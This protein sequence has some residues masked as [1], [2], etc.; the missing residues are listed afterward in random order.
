MADEIFDDSGLSG[1]L[2]DSVGSRQASEWETDL[3]GSLTESELEDLASEPKPDAV[4]M[5]SLQDEPESDELEREIM[6]DV[7]R[8]GLDGHDISDSLL[9]RGDCD[10]WGEKDAEIRKFVTAKLYEGQSPKQIVGLL[11]LMYHP[12][13]AEAFWKARGDEALSKYGRLG[14]LYVDATDFRNDGEMDKA[15]GGQRKMGQMALEAIKPA[16]RCGD[17]T[18]NKGGFC[19]RYNLVLDDSPSVKNARQAR[20]ILNKFARRSEATDLQVAATMDKIDAIEADPKSDS[21]EYDTAVSEFLTVA[22]R[23]SRA[24]KGETARARMTGATSDASRPNPVHDVEIEAF[25]LEKLARKAQ[26]GFPELRGATM[27]AFGERRAKAWFRSNRGSVSLMMEEAAQ[28]KASA[29]EAATQDRTMDA[30]QEALLGRYGER[31]TA[32]FLA[33]RGSDPAT[34]ADL[35][36][37]PDTETRRIA[38]GRQMPRAMPDRSRPRAIGHLDDEL[39]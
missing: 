22:G 13:R 29:S 34:Y 17:C 23:P 3:L 9:V 5:A 28:S 33:T 1:I 35:L 30:V 37:K 4:R 26:A 38:T 25:V 10:G 6:R 8:S 36:A 2:G 39:R 19:M 14:F 24:A 18:L 11:R 12:A 16:A 7:N 15:L 31:R 21:A 20:R 27:A 32:K